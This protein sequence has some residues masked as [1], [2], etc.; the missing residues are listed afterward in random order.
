LFFVIEKMVFI[1]VK[2]CF[3][4]HREKSLIMPTLIGGAGGGG[5]T[6]GAGGGF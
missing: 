2:S 3:R 5:R 4:E 6:G 1:R